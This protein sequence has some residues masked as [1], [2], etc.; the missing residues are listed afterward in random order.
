MPDSSNIST[1]IKGMNTDAH[2]QQLDEQWYDYALNA[3]SEDT[4]GQGQFLQN[5]GSTLKA[6]DIPKGYKVIK[7]LPIIEQNRIL[8]FLTGPS[9]IIGEITG[10]NNPTIPDDGHTLVDNDCT[11]CDDDKRNAIAVTNT[12]KASLRYRTIIQAD[13]LNFNVHFPIRAVYRSTDCHVEVVFN[14]KLNERRRIELEFSNQLD[15]TSDLLVREKYLVVSSYATPAADCA[16]DQP[17]SSMEPV[18]STE[19]DCR[20]LA[21]Q[22]KL[23]RLEVEPTD[24]VAGGSLEA[25]VYQFFIAH[26]DENGNAL[27]A[28]MGATNPFPLFS[29][30]ITI[31]TDYKTGKA[32][33]L[34]TNSIVGGVHDYFNIAVAKTV[35]NSTSFELVGTY[36]AGTTRVVYTGNDIYIKLNSTD[37][38]DRTPY[39]KTADDVTTSNNFLFFTGPAEWPKGNWQRVANKISLKWVT[40]EMPIGSYRNGIIASRYKS[41][42]RDE[43]YAYGVVFE[44]D[45]GD[46]TPACLLVNR[47]AEVDDLIN[48][49]STDPNAFEGSGPKWKFYN[50]ARVT[51]SQFQ[52]FNP[53]NPTVATPYQEGDF[54]YWES[55]EK[56]PDN[57][58][59]WGELA[60]KPVR[61]FK[62]PDFRVSPFFGVAGRVNMIYPIGVKVNHSSVLDA[63]DEALAC[64]LI[65]AED[66]ARLKGYRIVRGNR[67]GWNSIVAKGLVYDSWS[68]NKKNKTF[69]YPNYP[70]NDHRPDPFI[71]PTA[72]T[73]KFGFGVAGHNVGN[74][75]K[76]QFVNTGR[77]TFHSPETH[78][79]NPSIEG[80]N[81]LKLECVAVGTSRGNFKEVETHSKYKLASIAQYA[82]SLLLSAPPG[83]NCSF[84]GVGLSNLICGPVKL[85]TTLF[86]ITES[87]LDPNNTDQAA[88]IMTDFQAIQTFL[89]N[90][91]LWKTVSEAL[92]PFSNFFYQFQAIGKYEKYLLPAEAQ[93]RRKITNKAYLPSQ[94]VVFDEANDPLYFN[95]WHRE[96][97]VYLKIDNTLPVSSDYSLDNSRYTLGEDG[98]CNSPETIRERNISAYYVSVKRPIISQYGNVFG[99]DWLDT[100]DFKPLT[101][102]SDHTVFGGDTFIGNFGL[103]RKHPF[104]LYSGVGFNAG[105]DILYSEIGNVGYPNYYFDTQRGFLDK[106]E[107]FSDSGFSSFLQAFNDRDILRKLFGLPVYRFDCRED[108]R[109]FIK[110]K[111]YNY[112]YGVAY[113]PVETAV[114]LDLRHGKDNGAAD[115][116]PNNQD[117]DNWL[118]QKN[119]PIKEDNQYH[120]NTTYSKQNK[121]SVIRP[122]RINYEPTKVCK[123]LNPN[124]VIYSDD[125][126]RFRSADKHTFSLRNGKLIGITGIEN[127]KV[128]VRFEKTFEIFNAYITLPTSADSAI[129]STG[130]M[131]QSKPQQFS[132]TDLGYGGTQH[133]AFLSTEFGHVWVNAQSGEIFVLGNN[134][135]G[136]DAISARGMEYWFK[137]NL[138]FRI[139]KKFPGFLDADNEFYGVGIIL[140]YERKK[141]KLFLTKLDYE[142]I[143]NN[144]KYDLEHRYFYTESAGGSKTVVELGDPEHFVNVSWT[145][146]YKFSDQSWKS[147][148]SFLPNYYI[149][150]PDYLQYG[151]NDE[152][153]AIWNLGL[154]NSSYQIYS[155]KL[156]PFVVQSISKPDIKRQ[157]LKSVAYGLDVVRY[158]GKD[159]YYVDN[160]TFNKALVFNNRQCSGILS[161]I[162]ADPEN[163][164]QSVMYPEPTMTGSN[165]LVSK[166]RNGWSFNQ[167]H[168]IGVGK[169]NN[170]PVMTTVPDATHRIPNPLALDPFM[171]MSA[172][173]RFKQEVNRVRLINDCKSAYKFRFK[174]LFNKQSSE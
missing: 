38:F 28:Y 97:S 70:F 4:D 87:N 67:A 100:G 145:I 29:R 32:I 46:E 94:S 169:H 162:I 31:D 79:N 49:P 81:E 96:S 144:L 135:S 1:P 23:D 128:L 126:K 20:K 47:A 164:F 55:T 83:S 64:G 9:S 139:L 6:V 105:A 161:K 13:C 115:F 63:L 71:S 108:K 93:T 88:E 150:L 127:D 98:T 140:G 77:Y 113:F 122:L 172:R 27:S 82:A 160:V 85:F 33:V 3:D 45:N 125:W 174:W 84:N 112:S 151:E 61:H 66:R 143:S 104:F 65:S 26:A 15:S 121:E 48:V 110:G 101:E 123:T 120:Y 36:S 54:A 136:F 137:E 109:L 51:A 142:V 34:K 166:I 16:M 158:H 117:L 90:Y 130:K 153:P 68:Y 129:V 75:Y 95:N 106:I 21:F 138:P 73:Y 56:Y 168:N 60:G 17:S 118:Q 53:A 30:E 148:H 165:I 80:T 154:I 159:E 124:D 2:E 170:I 171:D 92:V 72:D 7:A 99:I 111:V 11:D 14:D 57:Q 147:F 131:F 42:L 74:A 24:D 152:C 76:N 40:H 149:S 132:Q 59:I 44:F 19:L 107:D 12:L 156:H 157:M 8:L 39:Y 62:F 43:V 163:H 116:Y 134:G 102:N 37:I 10:I 5:I 103:K 78:F 22:P 91:E 146:S 58:E 50:T 18:Y 141:K 173:E 52:P 114:N 25:G 89:N 155:G 119:V 41:N 167:F 35:N 69:Y 86:N 133:K